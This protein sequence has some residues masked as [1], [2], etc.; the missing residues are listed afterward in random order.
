MKNGVPLVAACLSFA[1]S[2][3]AQQGE[4]TGADSAAAR[5]RHDTV[6]KDL[7]GRP[8]MEVGVPRFRADT[9]WLTA[10]RTETTPPDRIYVFSVEYRFERRGDVWVLLPTRVISHAHGRR[11]P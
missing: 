2:L 11:S 3:A 9:A 1:V 8:G 6:T 10:S 5:W 4:E 7:A